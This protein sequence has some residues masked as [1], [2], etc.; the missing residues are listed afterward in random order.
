[1]SAILDVKGLTRR[2]GGVIAVNSADLAVEEGSLHG[3]IGPNG[4]GKTTL[5]NMITG[6]DSIDAGTVTFRGK[7]VTGLG[8]HRMAG[9]GIARSFQTSQLFD[10]ENVLNNV[11]AGRHLHIG[12]HFPNTFIY[13]PWTGRVERQNRAVVM[14]LLEQ[15]GIADDAQRLVGELPYGRRRLVEIARAMAT[16]P[17]LL[18][19]DE[20][21][22]GLPGSDVT[23]LGQV[24][25]SLGGAGYTVLIIEHNL[26]LLMEISDRLTVLSEGRVIA[27]GDPATVRES[28]AVIEAYIGKS[29][30]A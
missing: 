21:A 13:T 2:F 3:L 18:V 15:L 19:L 23:V 28:P 26:E 30:D 17:K 6:V 8:S 11:M 27:E 16:E 9:L 7:D 29:D 25:K 5:V 1:V 24:L 14:N 12:Y 10:E 20:P 22:A 4:A